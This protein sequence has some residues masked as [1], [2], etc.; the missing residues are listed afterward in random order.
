MQ[1]T[2]IYRFFPQCTGSLGSTLETSTVR[3]LLP[4]NTVISQYRS[5]LVIPQYTSTLIIYW[6]SA[7]YT[8]LFTGPSNHNSTDYS[9]IHQENGYSPVYQFTSI[10]L[11]RQYVSLPTHNHISGIHQYTVTLVTHTGHQLQHIFL[12]YSKKYH[13]YSSTRDVLIM[14]HHLSVRLPV[15]F[16]TGTFRHKTS[17]T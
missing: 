7:K 15:H 2:A 16:D 8:D 5:T 13:C 12:M 17:A 9:A 1:G 10:L 6:F 11:I 14:W 3:Q 4:E